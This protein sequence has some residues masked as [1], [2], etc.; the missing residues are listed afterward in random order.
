[1]RR[2]G[3]RPFAQPLQGSGARSGRAPPAEGDSRGAREAGGGDSARDE[4]A[5]GDAWMTAWVRIRLDECTE[6]VSG[7]TPDTSEPSYWDGDICWATP[8]DL[9]E[10][11]GAYISDTPRKITRRGLESC[12]ASVLP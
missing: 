6:V 7:A 12:A 4:G 1:H 5:G 2:A 9:S 11:K 8:K 3:L 10:L